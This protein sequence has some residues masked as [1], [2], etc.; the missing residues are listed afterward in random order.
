MNHQ[1]FRLAGSGSGMTVSMM[2][3]L[4]DRPFWITS[5]KKKPHPEFRDEAFEHSDASEWAGY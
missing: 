3:C 5:N 2:N 4:I 1:R